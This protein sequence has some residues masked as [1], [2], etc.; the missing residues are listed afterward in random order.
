[1]RVQLHVNSRSGQ[2]AYFVCCQV[3]HHSL[4]EQS[5]IV[6]LELRGKRG[7]ESVLLVCGQFLSPHEGLDLAKRYIARV[8][9]AQICL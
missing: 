1:M 5:V 8:V 7:G 6:N 3:V 9:A 4:V 2:L